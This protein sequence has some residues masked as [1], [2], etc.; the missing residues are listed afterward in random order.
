M[1]WSAYAP[2]PRE[3][4]EVA[5]TCVDCGITVHRVLGPGFKES[6]YHEAYRLE[7]SSRGVAYESERAILVRYKTWQTVQGRLEA[8]G[9][10]RLSAAPLPA[11]RAD[12]V[13]QGARRTRRTQRRT[14]RKRPS[15]HWCRLADRRP[16]RAGDRARRAA[17]QHEPHVIQKRLVFPAAFRARPRRRRGPAAS[18][19]R[20]GLLC[21]R[22]A[23]RAPS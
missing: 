1:S 19:C 22:G 10:L 5:S 23:L 12:G 6:I 20:R 7:L 14:R 21:A 3:V 11:A 15:W 18:V 9:P 8:G 4:E 16:K 13:S 17:G 2:I